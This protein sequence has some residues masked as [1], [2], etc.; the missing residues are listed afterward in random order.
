MKH[1]VLLLP[2]NLLASD[3]QAQGWDG[4][5]GMMGNPGWDKRRMCAGCHDM[6]MGGGGRWNMGMAAYFSEQTGLV[7]RTHAGSC[8]SSD[9]SCW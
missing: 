2:L 8:G 7:A 1:G 3:A 5:R 6:G 9:Y 4:G